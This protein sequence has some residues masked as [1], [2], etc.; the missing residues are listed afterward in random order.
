MPTGTAKGIL[1]AG[2]FVRS[3]IR[4]EIKDHCF[5]HNI[6]LDLKKN[7]HWTYSTFHITMKGE[8]KP[9]NEL[10]SWLKLLESE[11]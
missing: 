7:K 10:R 6:E 3:Q 11:D 2:L 8:E 1:E 5:T 4:Q 9:I